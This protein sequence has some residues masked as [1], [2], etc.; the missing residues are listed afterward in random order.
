[1]EKST[2]LFVR[3]E[4]Y[5]ARLEHGHLVIYEPYLRGEHELNGFEREIW[6]LCNGL[7]DYESIVRAMQNGYY[8]HD[9]RPKVD[10][11]LQYML[12]A[13]II[14]EKSAPVIQL[15]SA[16]NVTTEEL[17]HSGDMTLPKVS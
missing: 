5:Y 10:E 17:A 4:G 14:Q 13:G 9:V 12:K 8:R 11:F 2:T 15:A 6:E 7:N 3:S 1:M 16:S